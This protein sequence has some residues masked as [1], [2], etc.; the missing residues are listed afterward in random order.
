MN[1]NRIISAILSSFAF[2]C[3][4]F[5]QAGWREEIDEQE[6]DEELMHRTLP[7]SFVVSWALILSIMSVQLVLIAVLWQHISGV[8]QSATV[9]VMLD[10]AVVMH[11]GVAATVLG[12]ATVVL[13]VLTMLGLA[14]ERRSISVYSREVE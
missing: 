12:W 5:A 7:P 6:N 14:F 3:I 1:R 13:Q 4:G 11:I 9:G 8:V 2:I 10:S